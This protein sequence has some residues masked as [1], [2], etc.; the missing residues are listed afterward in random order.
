M[1]FHIMT[2]HI[3]TF[4]IMTFHMMTFHMMTFHMMTLHI[5][6][7]HIMT[8]HIMTFH[9]KTLHLK[10]FC[11]MLWLVPTDVQRSVVGQNVAARWNN[12]LLRVYSSIVQRSLS[13]SHYWLDEFF[14][15]IKVSFGSK[16]KVADHFEQEI[17]KT[18]S[19]F[20]KVFKIC[21]SVCATNR[22]FKYCLRAK[23]KTCSFAN[24]IKKNTFLKINRHRWHNI[25]FYFMALGGN[26]V[27]GP[28]LWLILR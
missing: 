4:H 10:T 9:I 18:V 8:F 13:S 11:P 17:L 22:L 7:F 5:M 6:T 19:L 1:P 3:M 27:H 26:A 15:R 28:V 2:F 12:F 21:P 23:P 25:N 20:V 16:N 24:S 14:G